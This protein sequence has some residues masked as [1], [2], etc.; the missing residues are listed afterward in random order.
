MPEVLRYAGIDVAQGWLD[1]AVHGT[2]QPWRVTPDE[3]GI[4][5]LIDTL[6]EQ[7]ID[8]VVLEATGGYE[9]PITAALGIEG[10]P[11]AVVN[12]R[13]VRELCPLPG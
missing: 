4:E 10:I 12:P 1:V 11:A 13:Q 8:L 7:G 5:G 3:Q 6:R 9:V 2:G